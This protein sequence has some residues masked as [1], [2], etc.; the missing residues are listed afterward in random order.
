MEVSVADMDGSKA[1]GT[2]R[3]AL[4]AVIILS[5]LVVAAFIGVVWGFTRQYRIYRQGHAAPASAAV[6]GGPAAM[7]RLAPGAH[8][9]SAATDAGKLVLHVTAPGGSE[10]DIF[11]LASGELTS[12][13]KDGP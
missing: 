5:L 11:D 4:A 12:Q 3:A 13:V 6:T 7:V 2:Y 1:G 10:V 9:V 8:I